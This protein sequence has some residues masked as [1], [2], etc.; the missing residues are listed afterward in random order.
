MATE[1][2]DIDHPW[3]E[4]KCMVVE[5]FLKLKLSITKENVISAH[6]EYVGKNFSF[7]ENI[8]MCDVKCSY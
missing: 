2:V 6:P 7:L 5:N 3:K 4:S 8:L 1:G